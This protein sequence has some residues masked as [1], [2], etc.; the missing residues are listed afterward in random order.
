[1]LEVLKQIALLLVGG[2]LAI[3][4]FVAGRS[5]APKEILT[6]NQAIPGLIRVQ[7]TQPTAPP[8]P[9]NDAREL[10]PL[11]P[12]GQQ[13]PPGQGQKPQD[14]PVQIFQDGKLYTFPQPG[15]QPQPGQPNGNQPGGTGQPQEI[16]PLQPETPK[17]S[18]QPIT[19]QVPAQPRSVP[20][21]PSQPSTPTPSTPNTPTPN[22][23]PNAPVDPENPLNPFAPTLPNTRS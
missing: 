22:T 3:G 2:L 8:T 4:G 16:I 17:T 20:I 19:P 5:S 10:I 14:C 1:V 13:P 11:N 7:N 21:Q 12:N 23:T 9:N 15:Q 6:V 18:P